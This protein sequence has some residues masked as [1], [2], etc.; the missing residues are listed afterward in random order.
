MKQKQTLAQRGFTIVELLIVVAVIAILAALILVGYSMVTSRAKSVSLQS[1]LNDASDAIQV[2]G[3]NNSGIYPTTL[4]STVTPNPDSV[5][6]LAVSP[7]NTQFCV[8]AYKISSYEVLSYDSVSGKSHPYLCPGALQGSPVGGSVP[9]VPL[10]INLVSDFSTWTLTGGASYN[11]ATGEITFTGASGT[12]TSPLIRM[13]GSATQMSCTYELYSA[14]SSVTFTPQAG[15]YTGSTYFGSDGTTLVTN[16][17][18]Y[19]GNGNAQAVPLSTYTARTWSI[20]AGP[21]VQYVRFTINMAPTTYTSNNFK[22]RNPSI[23]RTS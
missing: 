11:S 2:A 19:T 10:N 23:Q 1:S 7:T 14:T 21:N 15:M 20:Q 4:P 9:A 17:I 6:Q 8:N 16:S 3:I 13:G 18:G 5:I 12:A 22:V